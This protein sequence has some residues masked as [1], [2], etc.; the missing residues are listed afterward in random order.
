L[1]PNKTGKRERE[2]D[3]KAAKRNRL[4][5]GAKTRVT[6]TGAIDVGLSRTRVSDTKRHS[7]YASHSASDVLGRCSGLSAQAK[8]GQIGGK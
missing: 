4:R 7:S 8:Y 5:G 3:S 2:I 1:L 6:C